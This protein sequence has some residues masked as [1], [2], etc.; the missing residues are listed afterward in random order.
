MTFGVGSIMNTHMPKEWTPSGVPDDL[1]VVVDEE[2]L[3]GMQHREGPGPDPEATEDQIRFL[4]AEASSGATADPGVVLT[5]KAALGNPGNGAERA[6]RITCA[7]LW[8]Q[9][10]AR[11]RSRREPQVGRL[12]I[13]ERDPDIDD[14]E[15]DDDE[16]AVGDVTAVLDILRGTPLPSGTT[17]TMTGALPGAPLVSTRLVEFPCPMCHRPIFGEDDQGSLR[18]PMHRMGNAVFP[19][20]YGKR[21]HLVHC[22]ASGCLITELC[23]GEHDEPACGDPLC[24][25][26]PSEQPEPFSKDDGGDDDEDAEGHIE[27]D[28]TIIEDVEPWGIEE[29]VTHVEVPRN[30]RGVAKGASRPRTS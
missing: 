6:A 16:L 13:H 3:S 27:L 5:C 29:T 11:L 22:P 15:P 8:S 28:A 12:M 10:K 9:R 21:P 23:D 25:W 24:S 20:G 30:D 2:Y 26:L 17:H 7:R 4:L 18:I 14:A 1:K 19:L